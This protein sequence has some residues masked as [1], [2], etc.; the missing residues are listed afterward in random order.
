MRLDSLDPGIRHTVGVLDAG[1]VE[2]FESCE[3]GQGHSF[4]EPTVRFYGGPSEGFR[5]L[6]VAMRADLPVRAIRRYWR[7]GPEG[8]E[9]PQWEMVFWPEGGIR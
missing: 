6:D 1:R 4:P 9:G 3:G 8:P 5:A 7:V 2:T